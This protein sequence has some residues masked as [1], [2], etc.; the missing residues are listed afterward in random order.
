VSAEWNVPSVLPEP[1][2]VWYADSTWVGVG[3]WNQGSLLQ[4]GTTEE[5]YYGTVYYVVW[6]ENLPGQQQEQSRFVV[7]PGDLIKATIS[8]SAGS[9]WTISVVDETTGQA[10]NQTETYTGS[11]ATAEF[12][13]EAPTN[14]STGDVLPTDP[15]QQF[16]FFDAEANGA[17]ANLSSSQQVTMPGLST[18][19]A[20]TTAG[21]AFNIEWG[22][23]TPAAPD[24]FQTAFQAWIKDVWALGAGGADQW[25]LGMMPGTSPAITAVPGGFEVAF[26]A[27]TGD[28]WTVGTDGTG[29]HGLGMMAGTSPSITPAPGGYEVAFQAN[30]GDLWT[31]G[32]DGT[33]DWNQPMT[34]G[35]SPSITAVPSQADPGGFEVAYDNAEQGLST[36]ASDGDV[37]NWDVG[38]NPGTSPA[39]TSVAGGF[40]A[41]Y[42]NYSGALLTAGTDGTTYLGN[43]IMAST[44][45][46][47]TELPA[48]YEIAYQS[49][50]SDLTTVGS[51]GTTNWG[52]GMM[53][54]T[55]PAITA[56]PGGFEAAFQAN[57]GDLWTAGT[58]G[59]LNWLNPMA[60]GTSPAIS[61]EGVS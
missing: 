2:G 34:P 14:T 15:Y 30:T 56:V 50:G 47:I 33:T 24:G 16:P 43:A 5:S 46:A 36:L 29:N 41:V 11:T 31:T 3:G 52:L 61:G 39:I 13:Q 45:P 38:I 10:D 25:G 17:S 21:N 7:N 8:Q 6:D 26:Q 20:P 1:S 49:A 12:I 22:P 57:T 9:T 59:T 18:P 35:S 51:A 55:S 23:L 60:A 19:S 53:S 28:L 27:N 32:N 54:E 44:S 40:E 58:S 4:A 42:Q 37:T 48:G